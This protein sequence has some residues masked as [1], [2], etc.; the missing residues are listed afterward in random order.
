M[1]LFQSSQYLSPAAWSRSVWTAHTPSYLHFKSEGSCQVR[2]L[3]LKMHEQSVQE[4][5]SGQRSAACLKNSWKK[6]FFFIAPWLVDTE[7]ERQWPAVGHL[8]PLYK[9]TQTFYLFYSIRSL[10]FIH[11]STQ[12]T[13][14]FQTKTSGTRSKREVHLHIIYVLAKPLFS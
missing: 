11:C 14:F 13:V 8:W 7:K 12:S 2:V 6:G 9:S 5:L 3:L 10:M 1:R 4:R